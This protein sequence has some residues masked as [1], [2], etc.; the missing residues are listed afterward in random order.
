MHIRDESKPFI[1]AGKSLPEITFKAIVLSIILVIALASA[2][3]YLGLKIGITVSASIPASVISMG[4]LR[5]FRRSNILENNIVQTA[6]SAGEAIVAGISF[7]IPAMIIIHY[8][9]R[10]NYW[11]TFWISLVG[12]ILGVLFTIPLRRVLLDRKELRFPEGTAIGYVLQANVG[13]KGDFTQLIVG[14]LMGGFISLAQGGLQ[15]FSS[16]VQFWQ[17]VSNRFVYG[18]AIGFDP[19]IIAAGYIVGPAVAISTLLGIVLG[20]ILGVPIL[21]DIYGVTKSDAAAAAMDIWNSNIRYI[22]V[23][24]MIVGGFWTLLTLIR[25]IIAGLRTSFKSI[26]SIH[27]SSH[28]AI[29]RTERDIPMNWALIATALLCIPLGFLIHHYLSGPDLQFGVGLKAVTII[30]GIVYSVFAGFIFSALGGYF[31]G[32]FG[33][34]NSPTSALSIASLLLLALILIAFWRPYIALEAG[35]VQTLSALAI[36]IVITA[37]LSA[38]SIT[39]ETIQDLKAGQMVGATP[40]KQEV[41]LI[42]GT[43]VSAFLVPW[44]LQLLY[45]AYGIG[46]VFPRPGMDPAQMLAAP[47]AGMIAALAQGIFNANL[48][49]NM[50]VIGG[51]IAAVVILLNQYLK[52]KDWTLNVLAVGFGI[53][54]PLEA[55]IPFVIGGLMA[56]FVDRGLRKHYPHERDKEILHVRRHAGIT[57]ACGT[58]AGAALMGVVLAIPFSIKQSTDV[59]KIVPDTFTPIANVLGILM[60]VFLLAWIYYTVCRKKP[61]SQN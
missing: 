13:N 48:P 43:I 50:L 31:A 10:F 46:G 38:A 26:K 25:P 56:Y 49:W 27:L 54:L 24:T 34:T 39:N 59:W 41:M 29:P 11:E 53:Y 7:V 55:T 6:T 19:A 58:V 61:I 28:A 3:A 57:F 5:L 12:G 42:V 2:N 35:S 4:V 36:V 18:F 60:T 8:W 32:L 14:G 21:S 30:V 44:I 47:Q 20:W 52:T 33:S 45:E 40:W 1:P 51:A 22:G 9:H 17:S 23:G 15:I 37:V 16:S